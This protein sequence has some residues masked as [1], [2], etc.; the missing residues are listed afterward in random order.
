MRIVEHFGTH[1]SLEAGEEDPSGW[2]ISD[3]E[4]ERE[5]ERIS[6]PEAR[7]QRTGA[8]KPGGRPWINVAPKTEFDRITTI[9]RMPYDATLH[10]PYARRVERNA[11][12]LRKY[13]EELGISLVPVRARTTGHRIDTSR[14][15]GMVLRGDPRVLVARQRAIATDVFIA[16]IID[17]SGSMS[18]RD[19]MERAKHFAVLI[20]EA[21]RG[22]RGVDV[23]VF[24]FT[25]KVIYDC[26][27]AARCAAHTLSAS[28]GN[29][30]AAA[31]W[32][33]TNIAKQSQR[34]A[35]LLA[36]IS[37]GLPTECSVDALRHLV[38]LLTKREKMVCAQVAVQPI[39]EV[40]FP[41]YVVVQ[42]EAMDASVRRFGEILVKLVGRALS[43]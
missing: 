32:H 43:G 1:E 36:M 30:D 5:V 35:K 13:L 37:D 34:R 19:N 33:A 29:N 42:D 18:S 17:C 27:D 9:K 8:D 26:G 25:D 38:E 4:V 31:L 28:G 3:D 6:D 2:G 16:I 41:H 21:A 14:L 11:R 24:G 23:R 7:K 39:S 10:A 12:A 20:A 22:L 40:C 15:R